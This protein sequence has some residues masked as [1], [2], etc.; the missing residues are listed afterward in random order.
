MATEQS[1]RRT[2]RG[3]AV[4]EMALVTT[5]LFTLLFG[6]IGYGYLLSFR[7]SMQQSASEGARAAAPAP[8]AVVPVSATNPGGRSNVT[9]LARARAATER[10]VQGYD[11]RCGVEITCTYVVHDCTKTAVVG[12]DT[13]ALPDCITV[14]LRFDNTGSNSLLPMPPLVGAVMPD[15]LN[16]TSTVELNFQ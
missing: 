15:E 11:K 5:L 14:K 3:V 1:K 6:I 7:G 12:N 8:R 13:A 4:L 10:A 9:A 2:E 16:T